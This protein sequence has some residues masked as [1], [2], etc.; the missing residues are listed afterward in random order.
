MARNLLASK[1]IKS[2]RD[3]AMIPDDV[4]VYDDDSILEILNEE[5]DVGLL[6]TLLTLHEEHL[7]TYTDTNAHLVNNEKRIVIPHRAIGSKL[8]DAHY[9]NNG[10]ICELSRIDLSEVADFRYEVNN[11]SNRNDIFYVEGD[12]IVILSNGGGSLYRLYFHLRPNYIVDESKCGQIIDINRET[13]VIQFETIPQ[14]F[15]NL[16]V[17]DFVQNRSPNKILAFDINVSAISIGQ[18]TI[19]VSPESIPR[20][21]TAGDWVC[22]AE[23]S[24]YANVPTELHPVLAQRAAIFVLEAM[25]DTENLGNAKA[26]LRQ[27]E[28]SVQKILDDRVEGAPRKIKNRFGP[29]SNNRIVNKNRGRF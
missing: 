1:L 22:F 17:A 3:R 29:L 7:V 16:T 2:V 6:D 27:M 5:I 21:L 9:F 23:E 13:G 14:N 24:P 25:G 8:R 10:S 12:E 19:T 15:V 11:Y 4:S 26:K 18:R 28:K 20:R